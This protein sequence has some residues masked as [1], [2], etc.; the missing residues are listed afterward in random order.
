MNKNK[1]G[2]ALSSGAA[3]CIAHL[4]ILEELTEMDIEP[5]AISGVSGG[6]IVGA[7]YA[8]GYSPRQTLQ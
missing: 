1:I 5:E 8:N 4:G 6:A 7:F 3:R 2:L